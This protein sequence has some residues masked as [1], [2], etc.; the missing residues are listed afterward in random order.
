MADS[1]VRLAPLNDRDIVQMLD[2]LRGKKLLDGFRYLP[3][4]DRHAIADV[5]IAL[6]KLLVEHP[7]IAEIEI[8]PLRVNSH[9]ALALD[10]LVVLDDKT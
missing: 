2:S 5:A 3:V 8:N 6:G 7:E 1:A 9:G 4:C 10:A